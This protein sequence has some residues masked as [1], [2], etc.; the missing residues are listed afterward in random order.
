MTACPF[1]F[2]FHILFIFLFESLTLFDVGGG[3]NGW[4]DFYVEAPVS[5]SF[6]KVLKY[7][8]QLFVY[9]NAKI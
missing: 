3:K 5:Q 9:E 6:S 1:I 4:T 8:A 7:I 2:Y